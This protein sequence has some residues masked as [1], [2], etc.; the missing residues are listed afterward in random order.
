MNNI[1]ILSAIAFAGL[2]MPMIS[3][4]LL[5]IAIYRWESHSA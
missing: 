3:T 1:L 4:A 5:C 2:R